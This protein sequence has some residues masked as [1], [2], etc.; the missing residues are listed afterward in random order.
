MDGGDA[1]TNYQYFAKV[2]ILVAILAWNFYLYPNMMLLLL[3]FAW[4]KKSGMALQRY[5]TA[6]DL[7]LLFFVEYLSVSDVL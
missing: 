1:Y 7:L 2:K 5:G 4:T 6:S 3:A